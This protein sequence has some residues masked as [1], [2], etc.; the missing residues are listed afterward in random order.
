LLSGSWFPKSL[1][2]DVRS[3]EGTVIVDCTDRRLTEV[4]KGIPENATNLTLSINHIPHI[5]PTSFAHL[6][7]LM[8]IDFRCNC[9]PV[10]M[11][12]KDNVCNNTLKIENGSFA[13]LT[14]LK[15]LYLDANQLLE[16]PRGLPTTLSLLSL[17]ANTIYSIKK[18]NLSELA[19]IEVLYLGQNCY[20]RNPCNVSFEIEETAFLELK[21]ITI[22]SLKSNNLTHVPSNLSSTLKELYIYNNMIQVIQEHDLSA[23]H[24]LEILDLSGNC[25]RCYN[26]PYPCTPCPKGTI[27]IH[28]NAFDSLKNLRTLRLHSNSLQSIP[29][30]WFKNTRNLKNLDLSQ[31]FLLKEIG[32]A[33]FLKFIPSLV[34]LDLSFNFEVKMYSPSLNLSETFS[35]L[36]SL[37]TLR[38]RGY[39][40]K[41]LREGNLGPLLSLRNLTVLDLGT[42]FIKVADLGVFKKFPSLKLI[43]LSVNKISPSSGESNFYGFCSN[44]SISVEQ[45]NR[46]LLQEMHYF[47]YDVYG[48]SCRSKDKEAATYQSPVKED[49]LKYGETLDLSR[50]NIFFI[51][52]LD[53]RDLS[54]V[55]C[56]NLSDN[57]ISQTLNGSEFS[58]LSGLKYLDYSNNRID[59]LYSTAFQELKFLEI[60]DLSYNKHYFL[61]E[62]VTHVLGFVKNLAHLKKL[63]MN[64]NAISTSISTGMESQSLQILEF[65]GNRLD[66][67]W[68]DGTN[69]YLSFFKNLTRLEQLD[70]SSNSLSFLRQEVFEALP[71]ELRILNLTNNKMKSFNWGRLQHLKKLET[72]DLSN[73]LLATVPQELSNCSSTLHTLMLRN[74]RIQH[75]TKH[76]LRGA[77]KL[78]H[79]DLSSNKIQIIKKSSFP[80]SV[81][82]NLRMLLLHNNP[83][84]C[85]CDAVWFVWWINQTQVTIPLLATDVTCAGPG[86]HKGRS[87]VLLD[88]YTCELDTSYL[89]MY[90]LSASTVLGIMVLAVTSHLY[91]WDVW[92][93]Y[94]YCTAKL[95]G[96]QR[97]SSPDACYDAFV[98]YDNE[99]SAVNEWVMTE[100]VERLEDQKA[101]QFNLCLEERDWLP[102]QPVFDNLSQ[103]IQLSKKTIFV[104]TN[105]YIKSGIFKTTFY[106]AHQRL[107]DEKMDVIILIFLEKVLQKSRYVRL[108]KRLCRSSV[109]EWPMNPRA[110]PY[111]WQCLKNAIA[112]S[113][114]LAYNKLLQETV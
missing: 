67:L 50:N 34:D 20:Y 69:I 1:P 55:K 73:N 76:F 95:K 14:R 26:A 101:R 51:N 24:N 27:E 89:I 48:R 46:R 6:V 97:L 105:K 53:F 32:D 65:R 4:P 87:L 79:L 112:T 85:N 113:N 22:L 98:A 49:C 109:L 94:H 2:C 47:T 66:V 5:Y 111:F 104:L 83:F 21:K 38:I 40:F 30:S 44:P 88:L 59:L 102:G 77:S 52:P 39:V 100:L 84:K 64:E 81:I 107:L 10:R 80:E 37:E 23:L 61:A 68:R 71:P 18:A 12:P 93:S 42:N 78:E 96:Y 63:M 108:R 75:L 57:A 74:N 11:G 91:F 36:T 99:D 29:S 92:Y 16:I 72:L 56:L 82:N 33:K 43:D 114:T 110:Q 106:M 7:N 41:E 90:A 13:S 15:S 19:N 45:D 28:S 31:N 17:E 3:S 35:S 86:A 103:S 58:Y 8:E 54:S 70:I 9:V 25:P 60:L 62:G